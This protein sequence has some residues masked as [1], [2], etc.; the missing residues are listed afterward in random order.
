MARDDDERAR[1]SA[2]QSQQIYALGMMQD[3][4]QQRGA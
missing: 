3:E 1:K 4:G 2:P